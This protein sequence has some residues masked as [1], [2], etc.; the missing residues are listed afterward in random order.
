M[1]PFL[2]S[3]RI[4]ASFKGRISVLERGTTIRS[5]FSIRRKVRFG[6]GDISLQAQPAVRVRQALPLNQEL[7]HFK[8]QRDDGSDISI[9]P[10]M[11]FSNRYLGAG[12]HFK[13]GAKPVF[14]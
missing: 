2:A 9:L 7:T 5:A 10:D 13:M 6:C 4:R 1:R 14:S 8:A 11:G 12:A 3:M